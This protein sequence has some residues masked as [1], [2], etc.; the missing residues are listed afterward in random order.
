MPSKSVEMM[1]RAGLIP[2]NAVQQLER[3]KVLEE[4]MSEQVGTQ[5]VSLDQ[6]SDASRAWTEKLR[7]QMEQDSQEIRETDLGK[8]LEPTPVWLVFEDGVV[9]GVI[10]AGIDKFERVHIPWKRVANGHNRKVAAVSF[11][12]DTSSALKVLRAEQRFEGETQV[13]VVCT[14]E[15]SEDGSR[16]QDS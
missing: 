2:K 15:E 10:V 11:D 5:A 1:I 9:S 14:L 16:D 7:L 6:D 4:G 3:W 8:D 13:A 12:N